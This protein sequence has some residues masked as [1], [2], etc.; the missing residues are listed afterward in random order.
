[1]ANLRYE[2]VT[3]SPIPNVTVRRVYVD[4]V[5]KIYQ[6]VPNGGYV[7]H[8]KARDSTELNPDTREETTRL[9]YTTTYATCGANYAFTPVT[10]KD[11]NGV[12]FTAYGDREFAARLK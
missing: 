5:H 8:D 12:A 11:E 7:L 2:I 6:I 1:M 4:G 3:P 10:V 9:G